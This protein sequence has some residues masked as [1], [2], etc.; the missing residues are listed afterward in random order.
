MALCA[1]AVCV[2]A[3]QS[4]LCCAWFPVE[5]R[6]VFS[7]A[8]LFNYRRTEQFIELALQCRSSIIL[9]VHGTRQTDETFVK[10]LAPFAIPL[11]FFD[12]PQPLVDRQQLLQQ[13][14]IVRLAPQLLMGNALEKPQLVSDVSTL[15]LILQ[16]L[17]LDTQ[18]RDLVEQLSR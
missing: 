9:Q 6:L 8:L 3:L 12:V 18:D 15:R 17:H 14:R 7:I 16:A 13:G 4:Q 2:R 11:S 10:D 5:A 1:S